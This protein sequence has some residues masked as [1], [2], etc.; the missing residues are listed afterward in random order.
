MNYNTIRPRLSGNKKRAWENL[1]QKERRILVV[2]DIHAPFNHHDYLPFCED[3]YAPSILM[4][5]C[6]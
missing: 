4:I 2:G 6:I 1:N 5:L 3:V